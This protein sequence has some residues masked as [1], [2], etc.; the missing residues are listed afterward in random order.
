M[1][2][3]NNAQAPATEVPA[4]ASDT[5]FQAAALAHLEQVAQ[6]T[7]ET[8]ETPAATPEAAPEKKASL[9]A[10]IPEKSENTGPDMKRGFDALARE[11]AAMR[12]TQ[13]EA[14]D[15]RRKLEAYENAKTPA[16]LLAVRKW[17]YDDITRQL[18]KGEYSPEGAKKPAQNEEMNAVL[19]EVREL[20]QRLAQEQNTATRREIENKFSSYG[21]ANEASLPFVTA[22]GA[23]RM[24]LSYLEQY[25][26]ETGDLPGKDLEES[27]VMAY[28]AVESDLEK[29]ATEAAD[30]LTRVK[31][32]AHTMPSTVEK[33]APSAESSQ[34]NSFQKTLTNSLASPGKPAKQAEPQTPEDYR[35]LALAELESRNTR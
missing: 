7:P 31:K 17:G 8:K 21:K 16:D 15:M 34:A 20:K 18:L 12:K 19:E 30:L 23:Q 26:N 3:E 29:Q 24:A 25:V 9:E 13:N 32:P 6:T 33:A 28:Q 14:A 2:V 35:K 22:K 11:K 27:M 1:T 5:Q 4:E 10:K